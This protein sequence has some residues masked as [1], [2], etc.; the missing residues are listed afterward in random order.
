MEFNALGI[1]GIRLVAV[2]ERKQN[3]GYR[4]LAAKHL[5]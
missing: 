2:L 1:G 5:H 3:V 4:L